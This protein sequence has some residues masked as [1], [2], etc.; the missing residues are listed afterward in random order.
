MQVQLLRYICF[1]FV[2][3]GDIF[4]FIYSQFV[5]VLVLTNV[6]LYVC[7]FQGGHQASLETGAGCGSSD[8]LS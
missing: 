7:V 4:L 1:F 3:V 8:C 2:C 5:S 6:C